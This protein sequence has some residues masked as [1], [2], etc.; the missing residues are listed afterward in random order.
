MN[1]TS[2]RTVRNILTLLFLFFTLS[3]ASFIQLVD[4]FKYVEAKA[5]YTAHGGD[6]CVHKAQEVK[7]CGM[8]NLANGVLDQAAFKEC[9]IGLGL[10]EKLATEAAKIRF[11]DN[12]N[13][14][15]FNIEYTAALHSYIRALDNEYNGKG[16]EIEY[17][18]IFHF[19]WLPWAL[20]IAAIAVVYWLNTKKEQPKI[21]SGKSQPQDR[22][23]A[24]IYED[25]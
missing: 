22:T 24:S 14:R 5:E 16:T 10:H 3:E 13:I 8:K 23:A 4:K 2:T 6:D 1:F 15:E 25:V 18:L 20:L 7:A 19:N 17:K 12:M 11:V 9:V 21:S